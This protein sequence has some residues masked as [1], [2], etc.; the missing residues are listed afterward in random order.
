MNYYV[1]IYNA[2][3]AYVRDTLGNISK[4][5]KSLLANGGKIALTNSEKVN[6]YVLIYNA[7]CAYVRDTLGNISKHSKSLLENGGKIALTN[8]EK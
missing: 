2:R 3:C 8:S 4:H 6:Y 7:R 1:L 5:S